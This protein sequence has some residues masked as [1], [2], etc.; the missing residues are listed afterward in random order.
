M[1]VSVCNAVDSDEAEA[2]RV[3]IVQPN[4]GYLAVLA[5]RP[6]RQPNGFRTSR[7]TQLQELKGA[8][9][10]RSLGPTDDVKMRSSRKSREMRSS[11]RPQVVPK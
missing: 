11:E 10:G 5:R 4:R 1:K 8:Q 9:R 3:L 2:P 7:T 6:G